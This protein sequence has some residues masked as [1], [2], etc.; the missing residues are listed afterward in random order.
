MIVAFSKEPEPAE[1]EGAVAYDINERNIASSG[2]EKHDLSRV[3]RLRARYAKIRRSIQKRTHR[4][5]RLTKQL[6]SRYG[7]V[8]RERVRQ[9]LHAV[10]KRIVEHAKRSKAVIVL[11]RLTHI[12]RGHAKG[13]G[14]GRKLRGRLNRWCFREIQHQIEYKARWE[15]I[16]VVYVEASNTSKRCSQ[17]GFLNHALRF[18][19]AWTCPSCGAKLDRDVNAARNL[20][21]R[22]LEAAAVRPS[23]EGPPREA[24]ALCDAVS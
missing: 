19:R 14:E 18:E 11:E 8:E 10:T 2:G 17:C 5:R 20:R 1:P 7:R 4:D 12:R 6:L 13:N 9:T 22:Y 24:M 23:D 16:R 15:G 21:S 3:V